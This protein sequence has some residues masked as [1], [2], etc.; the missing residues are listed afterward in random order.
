MR[1]LPIGCIKQKCFTNYTMMFLLDLDLDLLSVRSCIVWFCFWWLASHMACDNTTLEFCQSIDAV[2]KTC[3][4]SSK[5]D[6]Y[7]IVTSNYN[8]PK[9]YNK[10]E[11]LNVQEYTTLFSY[12][13]SLGPN[14][15]FVFTIMKIFNFCR[16]PLSC[17][18]L[19]D[20]YT[21]YFRQEEH[22]DT[23]M[24]YLVNKAGYLEMSRCSKDS[25][26]RV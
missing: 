21:I 24:M 14:G 3:I 6:V 19:Y 4:S 9:R 22:G 12:V 13:A 11:T 2:L 17:C 20:R 26:G 15:I 23:F 25:A 5:I 10:F 7:C 16:N 18:I 1:K 8:P